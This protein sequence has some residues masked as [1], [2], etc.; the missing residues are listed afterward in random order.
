MRESGTHHLQGEAPT[1][2]S[3]PT[4]PAVPAAVRSLELA[5]LAV[6]VSVPALAACIVIAGIVA[7]AAPAQARA[8]LGFTFPGVAA[9]PARARVTRFAATDSRGRAPPCRR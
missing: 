6:T 2:A 7:L 4:V 5:R 1:G 3:A 8:W 9:R